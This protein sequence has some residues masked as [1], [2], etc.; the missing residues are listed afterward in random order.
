MSVEP[1]AFKTARLFTVRGEQ[2]GYVIR[3]FASI[4]G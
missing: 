4:S 3:Y 1:S 2:L